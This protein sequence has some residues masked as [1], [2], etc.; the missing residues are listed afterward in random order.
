ME[1]NKCAGFCITFKL[2]IESK[3]SIGPR[4][5]KLYGVTV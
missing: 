2:A 5:G 4:G 1:M 3:E